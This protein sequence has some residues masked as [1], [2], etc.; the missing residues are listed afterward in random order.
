[1]PDYVTREEF[2]NLLD[3]VHEIRDN[4]LQHIHNEIKEGNIRLSNLELQIAEVRG[5][6]RGVCWIIG[7]AFTAGMTIAGLLVAFA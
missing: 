4:H 7:I 6:W 1:M 5:C 2:Q 3:E